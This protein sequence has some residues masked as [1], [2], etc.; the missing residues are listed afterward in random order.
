MRLDHIIVPVP[1]RETNT[2]EH[3][4]ARVKRRQAIEGVKCC[5]MPAPSSFFFFLR[6]LL[7]GGHGGEEIPVPIP[8]TEVKLPCADDTAYLAGK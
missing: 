1:M 4:K 7:P 3:I 8:N 6:Q 5:E 2:Y